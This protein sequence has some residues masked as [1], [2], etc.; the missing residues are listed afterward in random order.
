MTL[1]LS[2]F[3][4]QEWITIAIVGVLLLTAMLL[5][6]WYILATLT[7]L[8][9]L[10]LL[11]F[12]RD[13]AREVPKQ[14]GVVVSPV[15]GKI[16]SV[17]EVDY[18]EPFDGPAVCVRV[19]ISLLNPHVARSPCH[20]NVVAIDHKSG[21]H[22]SAMNPESLEDNEALHYVLHHP[23][24]QY[25]MASV[26]LIAGLVARTI[27]CPIEIGQTLQRG[28]KIGI[29]KLGSAAEL[30]LPVALRPTITLQTGQPVKA[31]ETVIASISAKDGKTQLP[32]NPDQSQL[33]EP[34]QPA[35]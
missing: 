9:T 5:M 31:G 11:A 26:R 27:V 12:F 30:Y 32:T 19:F 2:H 21:R 3:A 33:V 6:Q 17:H 24:R 25:P 15:D 28:E 22:R 20:G 35:T 23:I 29:I 10:A 1:R 16:T 13:P 14:R 4:R 18:H 7:V 34:S 8:T